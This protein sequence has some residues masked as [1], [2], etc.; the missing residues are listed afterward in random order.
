MILVLGESLFDVFPHYKRF[1]GAPFNFAYHLRQFG[2]PVNF[3]TRVGSDTV[4][5][6]ILQILSQHGFDVSS[7]QIDPE[8]A[9]GKAI[10]TL[11][12]QG[13]AS[14][15]FPEDAAYDHLVLDPNCLKKE[16]PPELVYFGSL[17][18]RSAFSRNQVQKFLAELPAK[19][20]TFYDINLRKGCDQEIIVHNSIR[21]AQVL[22]VNSDELDWLSQGISPHE[23]EQVRIEKLFQDFPMGLVVLTKGEQGSA[24]FT[25]QGE[26]TASCVH[27]V[28]VV[29]TVGAGD[30]FS[31][32]TA[33]GLLQNWDIATIN[34][35]AAAFSAAVCGL[36]GAIPTDPLFYSQR[37]FQHF[38]R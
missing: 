5:K 15:V 9:T 30:A 14:Y 1:G 38:H 13:V 3:I 25:R 34:T 10:V 18:Q 36:K 16:Q 37:S 4:G 17:L 28:D 23:N 19:T 33:I 31:A 6:E 7:V 29:D 8:H 11:D 2:Y 20:C 27:Q 12:G 24:I 21:H 35:R 26:K 22:K 32:A